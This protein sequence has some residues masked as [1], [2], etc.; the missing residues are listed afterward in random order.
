MNAVDSSGRSVLHIAVE[1]G[2]L[3]LLQLLVDRGARVSARD[4]EGTTPLMSCSASY[5][6]IAVAEFLLEKGVDIDAQD[7]EGRTAL[8]FGVG[9]LNENFV[10][11]LLEKGASFESQDQNGRTPL[12]RACAVAFGNA[13]IVHM[14]LDRGADPATPDKDGRT[15]LHYGTGSGKIDVI[16][17]LLERGADIE[18]VDTTG[19]TPLHVASQLAKTDAM[20]FLIENK[21][22]IDRRARGQTPL[23]HLVLDASI[24]LA[25][26]RRY[27]AVKTLFD[28][29]ASMDGVAIS[30][31]EAGDDGS[32]LQLLIPSGRVA[33]LRYWGE[34]RARDP[35]AELSD[36]PEEVYA[37]GRRAVETYVA[38]LKKTDEIVRRR[39]VCLVGPSRAGKTSFRKSICESASVLER[40][41]DRSVGVDFSVLKLEADEEQV[42]E[43]SLW[44]FAGQ[45]IY[46]VAHSLFFS[47]RT[48]YLVFVSAEEYRHQLAELPM[49]SLRGPD[50][51]VRKWLQDNLFRWVRLVLARQPDAELLIVYSKCDTVTSTENRYMVEDIKDRVSE[52]VKSFAVDQG[53]SLEVA[54]KN[55]LEQFKDRDG[56]RLSVATYKDVEQAQ[57]DLKRTVS[58]NQER[59]F[60][61]P[62]LYSK[63]LQTVCEMRLS[64]SEHTTQNERI[65]KLL[66]PIDD[67]VEQ[68]AAKI[69]GLKRRECRDILETLHFLG[70]SRSEDHDGYRT[71]GGEPYSRVW[72]WCGVPSVARFGRAE[73]LADDHI[74]AVGLAQPGFDAVLQEAAALLR[75]Y[76]PSTHSGHGVG[77]RLDRP[78][79][80]E[81]QATSGYM[82]RARGH[83]HRV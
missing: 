69:K 6:D 64:A 21:A 58:K 60:L 79:V 39:K 45:D 12:H 70:D 41:D 81:E 33:C 65:K 8:H 62:E 49:E 73:A 13:R 10:T 63:V 4:E 67:S 27:A 23:Q 16:R 57:T 3:P 44:D 29:G 19:K 32:T 35:A 83:A 26:S 54:V 20:R 9:R 38:S 53:E 7:N 75:S 2:S 66:V 80:L 37:R 78:R 18:A 82:P 47:K 43:T 22:D 72:Q 40:E 17:A 14:L 15:A 56:F 1:V 59:A 34:Q 50:A 74:P 68:L 46:H 25:P 42:Y 36:I 11:L 30:A 61:M 77:L 71:R 24:P 31:A 76:L 55:K 48:L 52:W 28:L 5:A 51:R